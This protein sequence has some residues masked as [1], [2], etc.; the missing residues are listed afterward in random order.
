MEASGLRQAH[1]LTKI[2]GIRVRAEQAVWL[3]PARSLDE[4]GINKQAG[5]GG[6]TRLV[7]GGN[8]PIEDAERIDPDQETVQPLTGCFMPTA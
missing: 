2:K 6:A 3:D 5:H 1:G 8:R 4:Y 7:V